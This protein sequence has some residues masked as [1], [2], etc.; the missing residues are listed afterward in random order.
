MKENK[1]ISS[2]AKAKQRN[3]GVS[4]AIM[5][6]ALMALSMAPARSVA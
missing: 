6:N 2:V 1:S 5:A 3:N 4:M